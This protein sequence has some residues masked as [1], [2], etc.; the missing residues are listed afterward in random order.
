MDPKVETPETIAERI[1]AYKWLPPEQTIVTSSC[2]LNHLP[3]QTAF[4]KLK[5]MAAA[6]PV[7]ATDV[8]GTSEAIED[9]QT[10][11]LIPPRNAKALAE[12]VIYLLQDRDKAIQ[13]GIAGR[14]RAE[15]LF[16]LSR[17][18]ESFESLYVQRLSKKGFCVE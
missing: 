13:M 11:F 5:A 9:G 1:L 14:R 8:G 7:I 18:R 10:G 16:S 2:G 6:K 12:K 3:R 17:M 15:S 4:A